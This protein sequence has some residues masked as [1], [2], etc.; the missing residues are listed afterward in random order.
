VVS[1]DD[2]DHAIEVR[3][4]FLGFP[5]YTRFAL[6][7]MN[8]EG[9]VYRLQSLENE[10]INFVVVPA[11]SFFPDYAPAVDDAV[12]DRFNLPGGADVLLLLVVT[13]GSSFK[14]STVNLMAPLLLDPKARIAEQI[15]VENPD[16]SVRVPL[17]VA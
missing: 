3:G 5:E 17:L 12:A 14:E 6:I 13:L 7:R 10:A 16:F 2:D 11:M 15:I 4:G 9:L 8:D 1:H